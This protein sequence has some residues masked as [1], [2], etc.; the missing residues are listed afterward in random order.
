VAKG[1]N[2]MGK[3]KGRNLALGTVLVALAG[4]VA[5]I[6]TAPKSG[7][8]TRKDIQKKAA[9][10]KSE[11][12]KK[13]KAL[14]SELNDL[15]SSGKKKA[16]DAKATAKSELSDALQKAQIAKDKAREMLSAIHEG[17]ADDKDLQKAINEVNS[18]I[19]PSMTTK[20]SAAG[21][22]TSI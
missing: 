5:G 8:E 22:R 14:H 6:L 17:D 19:E 20:N 1:E 9:Q 7:K 2:S 10:A 3:N 13:L 11:A 4:Y 16:G 12:E 18:A 15:I 21:S